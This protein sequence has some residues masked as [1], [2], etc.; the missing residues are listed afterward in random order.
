[1]AFRVESIDCFQKSDRGDL[2]EVLHRFA[3]TPETPYEILD[4]R[5][6]HDDELFASIVGPLAVADTAKEL[7]RSLAV[8]RARVF[9]GHQALSGPRFV[10]RSAGPTPSRSKTTSSA[11]ALRTCHASVCLA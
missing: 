10:R 8:E 5:I 6:V 3:A 4:E 11:S 7:S 1:F 2:H 9:V